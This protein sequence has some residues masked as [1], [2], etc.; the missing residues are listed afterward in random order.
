M[1]E[2]DD[3]LR[4]FVSGIPP[5]VHDPGRHVLRVVEFRNKLAPIDAEAHLPSHHGERLLRYRVDVLS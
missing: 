4:F 2:L 3:D 5:V 1:V